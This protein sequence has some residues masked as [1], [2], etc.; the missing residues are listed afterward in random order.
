VKDSIKIAVL[1]VILA[2]D[3]I[4]FLFF[5][6]NFS[7]IYNQIYQALPWTD[8]LEMTFILFIGLALAIIIS[9]LLI[10]T[11]VK[12]LMMSIQGANSNE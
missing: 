8:K 3:L 5:P 10:R 11:I 9:I 2:A 7:N 6:T 4:F 1:S 12:S